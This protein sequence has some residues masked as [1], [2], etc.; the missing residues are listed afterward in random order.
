LIFF[1]LFISLSATVGWEAGLLTASFIGLIVG[2]LFVYA[3][4]MAWWLLSIFVGMILVAIMY[5]I[6]SNKYT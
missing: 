1:V 6:W 5:I 3:G 4:V 2:L